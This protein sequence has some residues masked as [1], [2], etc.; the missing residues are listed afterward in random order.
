[1]D[2]LFWEVVLSVAS[3]AGTL[4]AGRTGWLRCPGGAGL[5]GVPASAL[6][7]QWDY[8]LIGLS[9]GPDMLSRIVQDALGAHC[10]RS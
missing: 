9:L 2:T 7:A 1:M 8:P 3:H 4:R 6:A 5:P 10:C